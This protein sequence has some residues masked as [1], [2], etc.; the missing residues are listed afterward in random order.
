MCARPDVS[1]TKKLPC[2]PDG[3]TGLNSLPNAYLFKYRCPCGC[4][5][6]IT[7]EMAIV[8][9]IILQSQ[10]PAEIPSESIQKRR[11]A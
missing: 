1:L 5:F 3:E 9:P 10:V 8:E 11:P 2:Y 4:S 6:A 7:V